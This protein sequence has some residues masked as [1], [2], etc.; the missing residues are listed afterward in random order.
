M[1]TWTV[2]DAKAR[3]IEFLDTCLEEG[4]QMVTR[5]GAEAAV[6]VPVQEWRRLQS[7]HGGFQGAGGRGV[8]PLCAMSAWSALTFLN[9][10]SCAGQGYATRQRHIDWA[11]HAQVHAASLAH[12]R[13]HHRDDLHDGPLHA[14]QVRRPPKSACQTVSRRDAPSSGPASGAGD[15]G[16]SRAPVPRPQAPWPSCRGA[17]QPCALRIRSR[18]EARNQAFDAFHPLFRWQT[19][20]FAAKVFDRY[21]HKVPCLAGRACHTAASPHP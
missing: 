12:H 18:F 16:L 19:E 3:F 4:P 21:R 15:A 17:L 13:V 20:R 11:S 6:L 8:Q 5:R 9:R 1:H 14:E 2:H 7:Q 10:Q